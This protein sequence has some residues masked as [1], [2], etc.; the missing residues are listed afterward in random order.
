MSPRRS[1]LL[2]IILGC[3]VAACAEIGA[4]RDPMPVPLTTSEIDVLSQHA[5]DAAW[6]ETFEKVAAG[7]ENA[8]ADS[9][10]KNEF[11]QLASDH[12]V[13]DL[14]ADLHGHLIR[15]DGRVNEHVRA[16]YPKMTALLK[17]NDWTPYQFFISQGLAS[18]SEHAATVDSYRM[19]M[20]DNPTLR[21]NAAFAVKYDARLVKASKVLLF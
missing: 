7:I 12:H 8:A 19:W 2:T 1:F 5:M 16:T 21:Q 20:P 4:A 10:L 11:K 18:A 14:L 15:D 3:A 13:D 6:L 17:A 9:A